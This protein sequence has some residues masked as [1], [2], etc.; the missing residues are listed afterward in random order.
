[1]NEIKRKQLE[2]QYKSYYEGY[3][4]VTRLIEEKKQAKKV[5]SI[6]TGLVSWQ[7]A[8]LLPLHELKIVQ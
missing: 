4:K 8:P 1:M 7:D 3:N 2:K 6:I 5:V